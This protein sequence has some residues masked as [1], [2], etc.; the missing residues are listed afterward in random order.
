MAADPQVDRHQLSEKAWRRIETALA[1]GKVT[2]DNGE[3]LVLRSGEQATLW[4]RVAALHPGGL[5]RFM[6]IED[7]D[8]EKVRERQ[9]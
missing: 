3:E 5:K 2:L 9:E 1:L 6:K 7:F 4:W 8:A